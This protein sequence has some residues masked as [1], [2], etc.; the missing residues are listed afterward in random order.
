MNFQTLFASL[1]GASL[2]IFLAIWGWGDLRGFFSHATRVGL[3]V[4]T[5]A[6]AVAASFSGTSG[7]S[8]VR[9][10]MTSNR[11]VVIVLIVL[12]FSIGW[13]APHTDS[14]NWWVIDGDAVQFTGLALYL[15]AGLLRLIPVFELKLIFYSAS[16][17][18][19]LFQDVI[20]A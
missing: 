7:F 5:I 19:C 14:H 20:M 1:G 18:R 4:V 3:V 12:G 13:L 9:R 15:F 16:R 6:L 2:Y 11:W 17:K 10:E 8:S